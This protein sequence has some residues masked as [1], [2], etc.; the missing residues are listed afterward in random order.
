MADI[1]ISDDS[2]TG[3]RDK[4]VLITGAYPMHPY[5]DQQHPLNPNQA[6]PWASAAPPHSYV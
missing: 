2:L 3:V 5:A 4:I 6:A 1:T